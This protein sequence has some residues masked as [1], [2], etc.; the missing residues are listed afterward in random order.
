M[1][2]RVFP[3]YCE[4]HEWLHHVSCRS[5]PSLL[6]YTSG[7]KI[8]GLQS[9]Q[10]CWQTTP[11]TYL[12]QRGKLFFI[13]S[14][15]MRLS[16]TPP[17]SIYNSTLCHLSA[18]RLGSD[19]GSLSVTTPLACLIWLPSLWLTGY[20]N[21]SMCCS[22]Q[23]GSG[24]PPFSVQADAEL[25]VEVPR[26]AREKN[27]AGGWQC[28]SCSSEG[29]LA[30]C[31]PVNLISF[32]KHL[33]HNLEA[34]LMFCSKIVIPA[35]WFIFWIAQL[36]F[37]SS[38]L[39]SFLRLVPCWFSWKKEWWHHLLV[40]IINPQQISQVWNLI[41]FFTYRCGLKCLCIHP[42]LHA[43]FLF[44]KIL[45][46]ISYSSYLILNCLRLAE[47]LYNVSSSPTTKTP[48]RW[49]LDNSST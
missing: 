43:Q 23:S 46:L 2:T 49:V 40:K 6:K 16:Y 10:P 27:W 48:C 36:W 1:S 38:A 29:R 41:F 20:M 26:P 12:M 47:L 45:I 44:I 11:N 25:T 30:W 24:P 31:S 8:R 32:K 34:F 18:S 39:W 7:V 13:F 9:V 3:I 37:T 19:G 5:V 35:L 17:P 22:E 42:T 28:A 15:V 14:T 4:I 33:V 21:I